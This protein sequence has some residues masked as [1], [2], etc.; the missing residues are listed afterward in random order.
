M[1]DTT[2]FA[3]GILAGRH[4]L[5]TGGGTGIG[6]AIARELGALGARV[7]IAA[8][9]AE[10]L[11]T[12][13]AELHGTGIDAAWRP[14]NIRKEADVEALYDWVEAER[15]LPDIL[16]NNAGGQFGAKAIDISPNGFRAVVDLNVQGTWHMC[17]AQAR[18]LFAA[19]HQGRIVN[20]VFCDTDGMPYF[21]HAAAARAA[22]VNLTKTLAMEWGRQGI[23]VNAVGPGPI[24]TPAI[25]QYT[26]AMTSG[27]RLGKLPIPRMGTPCECALAVAFLCSAAGDYI[28]GAF[29]P[30]DGGSALVGRDLPGDAS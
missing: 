21:A 1:T 23:L 5:V 10:R 18:R 2:V 14:V 30:V 24:E 28:T 17:H 9:T 13:A 19:G 16:V 4:A 27:L 8:R 26:G 15:G 3:A 7:T 20:V 25:A 22:V 29:I 12:A 11:P 6:F